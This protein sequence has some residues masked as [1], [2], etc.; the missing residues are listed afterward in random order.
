MERKRK[1]INVKFIVLILSLIVFLSMSVFTFAWFTDSKSYTGTLNFGELKLKVSGGV[2]GDGVTSATS[3]I[4]FDV[5]R[6][7]GPAYTL[8]KKVMP[9]DTININLTIDLEAGSEPAYYV[10]QITDEKNIFENDLYFSDDGTNVYVY[11]GTYT[12]KQG[13][14]TKTMV[15][16]KYCGMITAGS[17]QN[18]KISAKVSEDYTTQKETTQVVCNVF[19]IQRANLEP[20]KA[21]NLMPTGL[22]NVVYKNWAIAYSTGNVYE[23]TKYLATS[24]YISVDGFE[25]LY[26][27][28]TL[29]Y[30]PA[31]YCYDNQFKYLGPVYIDN[32][33][34]KDKILETYSNASYFGI[35]MPRSETKTLEECLKDCKIKI[36]GTCEVIERSL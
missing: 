2:S 32:S 5:T 14:T 21:I 11:N 22:V 8:T 18:L 10:V 35:D 24:S 33:I 25:K 26:T 12:Y 36:Y 30:N 20:Q 4:D 1:K 3:K 6:T 34:T 7:S 27:D 15:E 17:A 16:D 29:G 28:T 9:G 19:A 13:D 31:L 23:H